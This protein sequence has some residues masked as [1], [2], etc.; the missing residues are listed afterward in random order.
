ML[1]N[2]NNQN[3]KEK[4]IIEDNIYLLD[5]VAEEFQNSGEQKE[6]LIQAGYIGLL[7]AINMYYNR[8][9]EIFRRKARYLIAGEIRNYIRQKHK[10]VKVP[11]WLKMI[12][13]LID[14][15]LVSYHKKFK[16]YPNITELSQMLNMSPEGLKETLKAREAVHKVS[17]DKE[18]RTID[19]TEP[20]D[21]RK[22]KKVKKKKEN[23]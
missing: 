7:N 19:I 9:E 20:P 4:K 2:S 6:D 18:R 10:K 5:E 14:Q 11:E 15:I 16:K 13:N 8:G 22:I 3:H 12:N 1:N 17:I 23:E 21:T